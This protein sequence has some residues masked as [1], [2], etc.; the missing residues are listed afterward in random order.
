MYNHRTVR[1]FIFV[2]ILFLGI[3]LVFLSF[4]ELQTIIETLQK[5]RLRYVFIALIVQSLWFLVIGRMY[6]SIYHLL[7]MDD[8]TL[9]LSLVA[10]AATFVN[11]IA[12]TAG[13]G[14]IALFA[15]EA[16]RRGHPTGKATVAGALFLL[17]DQAAFLC[18]LAVGWLI[19]L[20]RNHLS[21]GDITASLILLMIACAIGLMLYLGYRSARTLGNV[22]AGIARLVNRA[23]KPFLHRDYLREER[24][25]EFAG[26][27]ADGLSGVTHEPRK[28]ISPILF[29]LLNK[30]LL[31]I[32][33]WCSFLSFEVP[34]TAG[35]I[36]SGFSIGYLFMIVSPTPSG[37]GVVEG[38]MA[39]ALGSLG[40]EWSQAVIVTLVYRSITFWFPLGIGAL[41]F[42]RLN[43]NENGTTTT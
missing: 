31:I 7:G 35:T 26:E 25:H 41:A 32:V 33:L 40:I 23:L 1:K 13:V 22:L 5:S 38:V 11:V 19:L 27:I 20:R 16:K 12:P 10:V 18:I 36:I 30:V 37:M 43:V 14:G 29:G 42:R 34:S 9:S 39:L 28:L 6:R 3:A 15:A 24:A 4:G 2:L 8:S 17:F 21:A